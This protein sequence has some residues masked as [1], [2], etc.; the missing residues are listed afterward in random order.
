M[1]VIERLRNELLD[2]VEELV[3]RSKRWNERSVQDLSSKAKKIKAFIEEEFDESEQGKF[4]G[5][6]SLLIGEEISTSDVE[7]KPGLFLVDE[8]TVLF[9]CG[10]LVNSEGDT[11]GNN[12]ALDSEDDV[13]YDIVFSDAATADEI[14]EFLEK[15]N[16]GALLDMD[17]ILNKG[18]EE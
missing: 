2:R 7:Y 10:G 11:L 18:D 5:L 9:T 3:V 4:L 1:K 12:C 17:E 13:Y 6:C 14:K 15:A 8:N 16:K